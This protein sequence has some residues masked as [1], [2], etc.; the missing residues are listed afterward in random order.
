[1]YH[2][3]LA[4]H[5]KDLLVVAGLHTLSGL[6]GTLCLHAHVHVLI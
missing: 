5:A 1:M 6:M 2:G 4:C 3:C